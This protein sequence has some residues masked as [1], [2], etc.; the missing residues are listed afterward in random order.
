MSAAK[1]LLLLVFCFSSYSWASVSFVQAASNSQNTVTS[2]ATGNFGASVTAG[3]LIVVFTSN[4]NTTLTLS[5][6]TDTLGN[7]YKVDVGP[8]TQTTTVTTYIAHA[9]NITAGTDSVTCTWSGSGNIGITASE[10]SGE[11]ILADPFDVFASGTGSGT[12]WDCGTT[13]QTNFSSELVVGGGGW[14][15]T[16]TVTA[17]TGFNLRGQSTTASIGAWQEDKTITSSGTQ[18]AKATLSVSKNYACITATFKDTTANDLKN[19][20][21][22][23]QSF[24]GTFDQ[25]LALCVAQ[26]TKI[27]FPI[28]GTCDGSGITANQ[29]YN[30]PMNV[31]DGVAVILP[32]VT[33]TGASNLSATIDTAGNN[34]L[35]ISGC[36]T[37][38][39]IAIKTTAANGFAADSNGVFPVVR[40]QGTETVPLSEPNLEYLLCKITAVTDNQHFT[41]TPGSPAN[42]ATL[43]NETVGGGTVATFAFMYGNSSRIIGQGHSTNVGVTTITP[44]DNGGCWAANSFT[45]SITKPEIAFQYCNPATANHGVGWDMSATGN[46]WFHNISTFKLRA[47]IANGLTC[48]TIACYNNHAENINL[49][50]GSGTAAVYLRGAAN[51]F[52][53]DGTCQMTGAGVFAVI[54]GG[55]YGQVDNPPPQLPTPAQSPP[56]QDVFHNCDFESEVAPATPAAPTVGSGG[57]GMT[58]NWAVICAYSYTGCGPISPE[59]HTPPTVGNDGTVTMPASAP[60]GVLGYRVFMST[61]SGTETE[62]KATGG[63]SGSC[64]NTTTV[65]GVALCLAGSTFTQTAALTTT[66]LAASVVTAVG[67]PGASAVSVNSGSLV[68]D[69]PRFEKNSNDLHTG[70]VSQKPPNGPGPEDVAVLTVHDLYNAG[71]GTG[72]ATRYIDESGMLCIYGNGLGQLYG[73]CPGITSNQSGNLIPNWSFEGAPANGTAPYAWTSTLNDNLNTGSNCNTDNTAANVAEG[74]FDGA[75]G[76]TTNNTIGEGCATPP[77]AVVGGDPYTLTFSLNNANAASKM[78]FFIQAKDK[79]GTLIQDPNQTQVMGV[80]LATGR[81]LTTTTPANLTYQTATKGWRLGQDTQP[82]VT[83]TAEQRTYFIHMLPQAASVQVGFEVTVNGGSS[84][85]NVMYLDAVQ[86]CHGQCTWAPNAKSGFQ[87]GYGKTVEDVGGGSYESTGTIFG[88]VTSVALTSQYTNST[89][90]FSNVSGGNNLAFT[91]QPSATYVGYCYLP[92]QAAATGGLN[93]QFTGPASPTNV[94]YALDDPGSTTAAVATAYS[95]SLGAVV[96]TAATN[97]P[98]KVHFSVANGTTAGTLQL[99][100]KSSASVTLQIQIGAFCQMQRVN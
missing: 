64:S 86:F 78:R 60:V 62:Q 69:A 47:G 70:P 61:S 29:T 34:G 84:S 15:G 43:S 74:S 63:T 45:S 77:I 75:F 90:T 92:Y 31:P 83:G 50:P 27:G 14:E 17:G 76:N 7:A 85:A 58:T 35:V 82:A 46:A 88:P 94:D 8:I 33:F 91:L 81:S 54:L 55:G 66:G 13:S 93:I 37:T 48:L 98:A 87:T 20:R 71:N 39:S 26:L 44:P 11:L 2:L 65:N 6:C 79:T 4:S 89:T 40:F 52:M 59:N 80:R 25:Q 53:I 73:I 1:R 51:G 16:G 38:C 57:T 23:I 67:Y 5:S 49:N 32:A 36:P 97:F 28:G 99:Q 72:T 96:N 95:T 42:G 30:L 10:Y 3:N 24:A 68:L 18:D 21:L 100:A 19:S 22:F 12:S 9:Y 41:C 56:T